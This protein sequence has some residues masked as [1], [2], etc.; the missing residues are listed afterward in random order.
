MRLRGGEGDNDLVGTIGYDVLDGGR[1]ATTRFSGGGHLV[2]W[3]DGASS[4]MLDGGDGDDVS[5]QQRNRARRQHGAFFIG[6]QARTTRAQTQTTPSTMRD[7]EGLRI[8]H[9]NGTNSIEA[10][11]RGIE[12]IVYG[13][14]ADRLAGDEQNNELARR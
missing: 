13:H 1:T 8:D 7:T 9:S 10:G 5:P 4:V 12:S 6:G 11:L 14:G 2:S 3:T